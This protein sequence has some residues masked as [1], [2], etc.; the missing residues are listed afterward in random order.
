[1]S[2]LY[3]DHLYILRKSIWY[4]EQ[5]E[6]NPTGR[7]LVKQSIYLSKKILRRFKGFVL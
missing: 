2:S 6:P 1:M 3:Q 4:G 5:I 7:I